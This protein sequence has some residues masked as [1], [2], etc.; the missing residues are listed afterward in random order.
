MNTVK[1]F[2]ERGDDGNYSVYI[3]LDDKTLNYGIH[4]TGN[5]AKEAVADFNS[6]Y[7]AW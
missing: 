5:T 7:E 1:A 6:A 4:G 2:I 3:D